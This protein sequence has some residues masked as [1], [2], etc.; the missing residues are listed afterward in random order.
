MPFYL[1]TQ[2]SLVEAE[3]EIAAAE[4]SFRQITDAEHVSFSVKFDEQTITLVS[5]SAP[6]KI[7]EETT[8][9][10]SHLAE[11]VEPEHDVLAA[12]LPTATMTFGR[13]FLSMIGLVATGA[14]VGAAWTHW[15]G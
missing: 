6:S 1:V 12:P 15:I 11:P 7:L 2:T 3:D 9:V 5:V 4:K 13:G 10:G 14:M 8:A